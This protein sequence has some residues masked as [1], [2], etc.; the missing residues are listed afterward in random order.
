MTPKEIQDGGNYRVMP[1]EIRGTGTFDKCYAFLTGLRKM[2]RLTRLDSLVLQLN[3]AAP[4]PRR[5]GAAVMPGVIGIST[6][7]A[8]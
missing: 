5:G 8:R 1:V 6:F 7:L 3:Q 4:H 2:N